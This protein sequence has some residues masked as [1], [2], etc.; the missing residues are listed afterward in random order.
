M[1]C[2]EA[3][4]QGAW[5][6]GDAPCCVES[7]GDLSSGPHLSVGVTSCTLSPNPTAQGETLLYPRAEPHKPV[8]KAGDTTVTPTRASETTPAP[9]RKTPLESSMPH[10]WWPACCGDKS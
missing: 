4:S 3:L 10:L 6:H 1:S 7:W 5:R 2:A 8:L 9:G